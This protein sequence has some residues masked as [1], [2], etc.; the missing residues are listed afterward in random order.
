MADDYSQFT[1]AGGSAPA[2]VSLTPEDYFSKVKALYPNAVFNGGGR[3]YA[4]NLA[5]GGASHSM[6]LSDQALDFNVPGVDHNQV[7]DTIRQAGLPVTESL[8]EGRIGSQGAH[9]H[10]GW[11]PKNG[12]SPTYQQPNND[13][14]QFTAVGQVTPTQT[15][16]PNAL[17]KGVMAVANSPF[18][19]G[20]SGSYMQ[21]V[22]NGLIMEPV[23]TVMERMG[24]GMDKLKAAYPGQTDDWYNSHLHNMYNNAITASRQQ[25]YQQTADNPYPGHLLANTAAGVLGGADPTWFIN[26]GAAVEGGLLKAGVIKGGGSAVRRIGINAAAHAEMG[27]ASNAAA[28]GMDMAAKVKTDFDVQQNLEQAGMQGLFG[29]AHAGL[30]E[31]SPFVKGLFAKRGL[32]TTPQHDP[33]GSLTTPTTTD[34]I[35]MNAQDAAEYHQLLATGDVDDIKGFFKGRNGPQPSYEDVNNWVNHRDLN[36]ANVNDTHLQ[37]EF[38][39]QAEYN[40]QAI[41]DHVSN[42]T[43]NWKNSP[44]FEVSHGPESIAD[45][46]IRQQAMSEDANGDAL[47]F[48]APDGTVHLFSSRIQDHDTANAVTYHEGLGH[49]GLTEK[50]G[51]KLDSTLNT[52]MD[53]NVSQ[54]GRDVAKWQKENPNAYGGDRLRAAEEVL[55]ER[56]QNG[57]VKPSIADAVSASVH[58]FG[59]KMGLKLAY[60]DGEVN[61][62]L[63]MAHDAVVNG[64]GRDVTGNGFRVGPNKFMYAGQKS[65]NFDPSNPRNFVAPDGKTRS[66]FSDQDARIR[67]LPKMGETK[68]LADVLN[69]GALF[70]EYPGLQNI[71]VAGIDGGDSLHGF[72]APNTRTIGIDPRTHD[73]LGTMLHEVQHV[74]QHVEQHS[75]GA[76]SKASRFEYNRSLGEIE[77][78]DTEARRNLTDS[79]RQDIEPYTS[80]GFNKSGEM[81]GV[82]HAGEP[83]QSRI[84]QAQENKFMRASQ[85]KE[86]V[87][88]DYVSEDMEGIYKHL[89]ENYVPNTVSEAETRRAALEHGISPSAIK[90][91]AVRDPGELAARVYRITAAADMADMKLKD[92]HDRLDTPEWTMA[93]QLNYG[94]VL[95]ERNYLITRAKGEANEVGRALRT[96]NAF[97]SY[98]NASL[99][100]IAEKLKTEGSGLG[101]LMDDP[102]EFLK[103]A[104]SIKAL[105][106]SGNPAGAHTKLAGINK[107][108]WE[109]YLNTF[110]MNAMLS[111]L[112]THVKAPIDMGTGIARD[113]IEKMVAI[114][115]GKV[116]QAIVGPKAKV[117]V[118]P[119]EV[120]SNLYGI[121]RSV[122]DM[123]V[124]KRVTHAVKTGEGGYVGP[125]HQPVASNFSNQFGSTSNPRIPGV[126]LPT[127]LISAQ[128]TFFRS[129]EMNKNLYGLGRREAISQLGPKASWS[130]TQTL[131]DNL[132]HNPTQAMLKEAH[133]LTDRALLLNN[134]KLNSALDKYRSYKPGL[135][136]WE[137]VGRFVVTN[138]APFIRVQSNNLMNRVIQR[139]PLGFLDPYTQAQLKMGGAHADLALARIAYGTTLIGM[140]WVAA[141]KK[142]DKL[143]GEGSDNP[144]K[145]KENAAAGVLPRSVHEN[146]RYNRADSL[147][148][149][150][151]PFDLH[152]ST[153]TAVASMREAWDKG[154]NKGQVLNGVKLLIGSVLHELA[155][156]SWVS[157]LTPAADALT[158][159]GSEAPHKVNKFLGDQ[160]RSWVPNAL[161]QT[162]RLMDPNQHEVIDNDSISKTVA[163]EIQSS[164]PN[165]SKSLP[166]RYSVYG[167]PLPNGASLTGVHT[168]IP[169]LEGNGDKETTD[170]AE[171]ELHRLSGLVDGAVV[172]PVQRTITVDG[173][174]IKLNPYQFGQ[175]QQLAG[176]A[177]VE[178]VRSEMS[179]PEWQQMSDQEKVLEV[180]DIETDMKKAAREHLYGTE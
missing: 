82:I 97:K 55:A 128:D 38:D 58:Q 102:M 31:V 13:Y 129:V 6:H 12:Q 160:A 56:S 2:P 21:G 33:S 109:Q 23:R 86:K 84:E 25:A 81:H 72:Y 158:V 37:P 64:K 138:L 79:E 83:F 136:P 1:P 117:G 139:S 51:D 163:N 62:I 148:L 161:G 92:L 89:S 131:G 36:P 61:S 68:Y 59:R 114:P 170:P 165:A 124:Y 166:V 70:D 8:S 178:T 85:M 53:R 99:E 78:R 63:A 155:S 101:S 179:T 9:L 93:D 147:S 119:Q 94:K 159:S 16:Q 100:E 111:G 52:L 22:T 110:H 177:I 168:V 123:E 176:R 174:K 32:D 169:G 35:A 103:F 42:Q 80:Q 140:Y 26:P 143:T 66:E 48:L 105:M 162:A 150:L 20:V 30:A 40:R 44:R 15:P 7:F 151:N 152:N 141:G 67:E 77:A 172:T 69:H 126:S 74:I 91:L 96:V 14:S 175:Y 132:A 142:N 125:D 121:I 11:A 27:S 46:A 154:A 95:A 144:N 47:G 75:A 5:V 41:A 28:Q 134:N 107:P 43:A 19:K 112:S 167:N 149:S 50:F 57:Q 10:V 113:V 108:Y 171:M 49:F 115:I 137:R 65:D 29:G 60:S 45:P 24:V 73:P 4:R 106:A 98:T 156:T 173:N 71:K 133:D 164:I 87:G 18:I 130:D 17:E 180:K 76:T 153:A 146:G 116:R 3:S 104:R 88:K 120:A 135:T 90:D 145:Y 127:D 118:T 34:R 157:D 39:Y 122:T 54:F